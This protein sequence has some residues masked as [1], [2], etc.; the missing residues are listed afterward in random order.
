[1]ESFGPSPAW[2]YRIDMCSESEIKR[3]RLRSRGWTLQRARH[4]KFI[5]L[6][7][8]RALNVGSCREAQK[9]T[10]K[11]VLVSKIAN[12][13]TTTT[14]HRTKQATQ[15]AKT[16][17]DV[18]GVWRFTCYF[19]QAGK[20]MKMVSL[21]CILPRKH[22]CKQVAATNFQ[23]PRD[24]RH[25]SYCHCENLQGI[26][27]AEF[28]AHV[29]HSGANIALWPRSPPSL[30]WQVHGSTSES[31]VTKYGTHWHSATVLKLSAW[32]NTKQNKQQ[33]GSGGIQE[34]SMIEPISKPF[35]TPLHHHFV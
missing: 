35:Q 29:H 14:I 11:D 31:W 13:L 4:M 17:G 16:C 21:P 28:L 18:V 8:H 5:W 23:P 20:W 24:R 3:L 26:P 12:D 6:L 9:V 1:M 10:T 22:C 19:H 15:I 25:L 27:S 34:S 33:I 7:G 30:Q 32:K 2:I